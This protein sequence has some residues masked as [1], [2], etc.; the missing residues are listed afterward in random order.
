MHP[1]VSKEVRKNLVGWGLA[2]LA[3]VKR[4]AVH[5]EQHAQT[6]R[7]KKEN[8]KDAFLM[9]VL[10]DKVTGGRERERTGLDQTKKECQRG[11]LENVTIVRKMDILLESVR[12]HVSIVVGR[13]IITA[14]VNKNQSV[15]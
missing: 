10:E 1:G 3:E 15:R 14:I 5:H 13:D 11:E 9:A 4:Y 2:T 12:P 6:E 8:R 7:R